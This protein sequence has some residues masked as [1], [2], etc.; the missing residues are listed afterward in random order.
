M[1]GIP[2][3]LVTERSPMLELLVTG[4][5][6]CTTFQYGYLKPVCDFFGVNTKQQNIFIYSTNTFFG[7]GIHMRTYTK[8]PRR[9]THRFLNSIIRGI[10]TNFLGHKKSY[11]VF[12][13]MQEK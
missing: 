13:L 4:N 11:I 2:F 9:F 1:K 12:Q 5:L 3:A 8:N 7:V 6:E 10:E